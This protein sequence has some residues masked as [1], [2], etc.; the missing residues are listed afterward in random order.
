MNYFLQLSMVIV[1]AT[2]LFTPVYAA[3]NEE[4][5]GRKT[6]QEQPV[7]SENWEELNL[8]VT[9]LYKEQKFIKA[10]SFN[11]Y[12]INVARQLPES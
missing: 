7:Q 10:S 9:N 6:A 2:F 5:V 1:V 12:V 11:N 3:R 4:V 8:K